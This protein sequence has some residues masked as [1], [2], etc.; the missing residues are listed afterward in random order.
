MAS[1]AHAR[2]SSAAQARRTHAEPAGFRWSR[3][4][5]HSTCSPSAA[6]SSA[7]RSARSSPCA[8]SGRATTPNQRHGLWQ[9]LSLLREL[10]HGFLTRTW[11][12][13]TLFGATA[14]TSRVAPFAE[15]DRH[16]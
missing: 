12:T 7:A 15:V 16:A 4:P 5:T 11:S 1:A 9:S 6:R 14:T 13:S 3:W 10:D 2:P 8:A